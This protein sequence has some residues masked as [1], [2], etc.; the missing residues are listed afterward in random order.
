MNA[1]TVVVG[2][3]SFYH[4]K[5]SR[6]LVFQVLSFKWALAKNTTQRIFFILIFQYEVPSEGGRSEKIN[7]PTNMDVWCISL[8]I[9]LF[10]IFTKNFFWDMTPQTRTKLFWISEYHKFDVIRERWMCIKWWQVAFDSTMLDSQY[11]YF[12]NLLITGTLSFLSLGKKTQFFSKF[13][14]LETRI[15]LEREISHKTVGPTHMVAWC[16][17]LEI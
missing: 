16:V 14:F 11:I 5:F 3:K 10:Q 15:P 4:S 6:L 13:L 2:S 1:G 9:Q 7:A 8:E 12:F 17:F